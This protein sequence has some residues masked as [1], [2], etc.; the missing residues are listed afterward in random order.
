MFMHR[1]FV[2]SEM[3]ASSIYKITSETEVFTD[4][5]KGIEGFTPL[6]AL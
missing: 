1:L 5:N 6:S 3:E 2:N 4:N